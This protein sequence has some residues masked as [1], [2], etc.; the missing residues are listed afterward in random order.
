MPALAARARFFVTRRR[1]ARPQLAERN[2]ERILEGN[3]KYESVDAM[4]EAYQE[5]EGNEKGLSRAQ[6][7]DQV[8]R[9]AEAWGS[10]YRK[11]RARAA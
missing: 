10:A 6:C 5:F 11:M 4:I 8:L 2:K 9:F 3:P 7:E 1:L